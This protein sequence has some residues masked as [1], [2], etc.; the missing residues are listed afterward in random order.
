MLSMLKTATM[1]SPR[2]LA[3]WAAVT[4]VQ[5]VCSSLQKRKRMVRSESYL[6]STQA[7]SKTPT[8]PMALSLAPGRI[9]PALRVLVGHHDDDLVGMR[10]ALLLWR[11]RLYFSTGSVGVATTFYAEKKAARIRKRS[12]SCAPQGFAKL[13]RFPGG[14]RQRHRHRRRPGDGVRP[15][16][17]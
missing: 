2:F 17:V 3:F 1:L 14:Q 6:A 7:N 15:G 16:E 10:A 9:D 8:V 13:D 5:G 11:K 12:S 4:L